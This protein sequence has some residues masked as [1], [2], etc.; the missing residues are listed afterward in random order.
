MFKI[1]GCLAFFLL[2]ILIIV[3]S[4]ATFAEREHGTAY[5]MQHYYHA[6]WCIVLWG[7]LT[8][9]GLLG[10]FAK[11]RTWKIWML[12]LS[13]ALILAGAGLTHFVGKTG[14][15]HLRTDRPTLL[16]ADGEQQGRVG[17]LPFEVTLKKFKAQNDDY[18]SI[19]EI[20]GETDSVRLNLPLRKEGIQFTQ[21]SYDP[22]LQ[23]SRLGITID[24]LGRWTSIAGYALLFTSIVLLLPTASINA[25][26][27]LL[28]LHFLCF[29]LYA[30]FLPPILRYGGGYFVAHVSLI[31]LGYLCF[32]ATLICSIL[33]LFSPTK[34]STKCSRYFLR[35]GVYLLTVGIFIGAIWGNA[36]W[37][38][39]WAWDAK[40]TWAL[41]TLFTYLA[42]LHTESLPFFKKDR[43]YHLYIG[44][45]F[46]VLLMTFIG[47]N[48]LFTGLHSYL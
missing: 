5:A 30:D 37:G 8:F 21:L 31:I 24:P 15:L 20:A 46:L 27:L 17:H 14:Q 23:G 40:E 32:F 39:F 26:V 43:T 35:Y 22:D 18:V 41:I 9:F 10:L 28:L 38:R 3:L 44:A 19:V 2:F 11:K 25:I 42:P 47:V 36:A 12:H 1:A 33:H 45:A 4:A 13:L 7:G 29:L 34:K 6:S 16:Y 48:F